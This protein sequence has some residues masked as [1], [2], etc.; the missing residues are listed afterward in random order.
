MVSY[1]VIDKLTMLAHVILDPA[2]TLVLLPIQ[3]VFDSPQRNAAVKSSFEQFLAVHRYTSSHGERSFQFICP[4]AA[5]TSL[6]QCSI[7][8]STMVTAYRSELSRRIAEGFVQIVPGRLGSLLYVLP[9]LRTRVTD[10]GQ[11]GAGFLTIDGT[12]ARRHRRVRQAT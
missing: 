8:C 12:R 10:L 11:L 9:S 6:Q 5:K 3:F 7:H 2:G 4:S 1:Q